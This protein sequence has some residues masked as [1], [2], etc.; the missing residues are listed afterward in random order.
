MRWTT[1]RRWRRISDSELETQIQSAILPQVES[2]LSDPP[3]SD[4]P[5]NCLCHNVDERR[6]AELLKQFSDGS[7]SK[8]DVVYVLECH[9]RTVSQKLLR[10]EFRLQTYRKWVDRAQD[11][12][13]LLY[14]GVSKEPANRLMQHAAGRGEGAN[15]TQIFPAARLLSLDWYQSTHQAYRAEPLTA[16][17]LDEATGDD[18]YV[19]QPG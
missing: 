8:T 6:I 19:S 1:N 11:K 16:D 14:V 13:R 4:C 18:I 12:D 3:D 5:N 10:E 9:Q 15:F 17:L 7:L 2:A